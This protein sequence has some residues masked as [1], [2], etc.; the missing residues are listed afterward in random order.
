MISGL[1]SFW[2]SC[3]KRRWFHGRRTAKIHCEARRCAGAVHARGR[4][5]AAGSHIRAPAL[6]RML[7]ADQSDLYRPR[8]GVGLF[9]IAP[10][11]ASKS[12]AVAAVGLRNGRAVAV[13]ARGEIPLFHR[14]CNH[15]SFMVLLLCAA[16]SCAAFQPVCR[17]ANRAAGKRFVF[18]QLVS[19]V[20]PRGTFDFRH[21]DQ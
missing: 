17:A 13:S 21:T 4:F 3:G 20:Y 6:R 15:P 18:F 7:S 9:H 5:S 8:D 16:D 1:F 11:S 14:S 19:A 12:A 10:D 2:R